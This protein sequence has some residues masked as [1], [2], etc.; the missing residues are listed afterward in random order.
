MLSF[1]VNGFQ[2]GSRNLNCEINKPCYGSSLAR[3]SKRCNDYLLL[4]SL[5][6]SSKMSCNKVCFHHLFSLGNN[7]VMSDILT[8]NVIDYLDE[9][10][11][12]LCW[13]ST[14]IPVTRI[15]ILLQHWRLLHKW[16]S[17]LATRHQSA[18]RISLCSN[19]CV[20]CDQSHTQSGNTWLGILGILG[21]CSPPVG[22]NYTK[23]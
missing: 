19:H 7:K 20:G 13:T 15:H 14:T 8:F 21:H 22:C 1:P 10:S 5:C 9:S 12:C 4:T 18:R 17:L 3:Q 23:D 2:G 16:A 6:Y 11:L